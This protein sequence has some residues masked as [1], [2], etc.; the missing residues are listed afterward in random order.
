MQAESDSA[1]DYKE[2]T[3]LTNTH[4]NSLKIWVDLILKT[5]RDK[6]KPKNHVKDSGSGIFFY[7]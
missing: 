3:F 6:E 5:G 7:V 2:F 1:D 4:G